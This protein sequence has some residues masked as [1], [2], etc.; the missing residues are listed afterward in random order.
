MVVTN[1]ELASQIGSLTGLVQSMVAR[2][3]RVEES[4][5]S[6]AS[7]DKAVSQQDMKIQALQKETG[8]L[9]HDIKNCRQHHVNESALVARRV[10]TLEVFKNKSEGGAY[11]MKLVFGVLWAVFIVVAG[12]FS[13][14]V[15]DRAES[16]REMNLQ[17][18]FRD[19]QFEKDLNEIVKQLRKGNP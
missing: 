10:E 12:G 18:E 5:K 1:E 11:A 7:L 16:N 3:D 15:Y 19:S 17:Q 4:L 6:I 9:A 14:W 13:K 2:F 8:E